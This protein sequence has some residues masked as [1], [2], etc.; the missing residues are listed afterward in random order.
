MQ[1]TAKHLEDRQNEQQA[2]QEFRKAKENEQENLRDAESSGLE[3]D[4]DVDLIVEQEVIKNLKQMKKTKELL[5]KNLESN[6]ED[7]ETKDEQQE[8]AEIDD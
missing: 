6:E 5:K 8:T 1:A 7:E 4:N 2:M 3:S